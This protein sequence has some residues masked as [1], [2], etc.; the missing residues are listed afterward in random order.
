MNTA[1]VAVAIPKAVLALAKKEVRE[2]RAKSLSAYVSDAIDQRLRRDELERLLDRM[3]AEHGPPGKRA[4]A[5]AKR[6][7]ARAQSL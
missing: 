3:D 6:V 1:K 4:K 2:G 5:W 7:L